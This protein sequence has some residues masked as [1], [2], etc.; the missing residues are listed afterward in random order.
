M[1]HETL[2]HAPPLHTSCA[3]SA[4][5]PDPSKQDTL[6]GRLQL[7][8]G[9]VSAPAALYYRYLSTL[10][11]A[12]AAMAA[13]ITVQL[14]AHGGA[15]TNRRNQGPTQAEAGRSLTDR[16]DQDWLHAWM[17]EATC[18]GFRSEQCASTGSE[19]C[20]LRDT[21]FSQPGEI[22]EEVSIVVGCRL[23]RLPLQS[24]PWTLDIILSPG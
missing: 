14:M 18:P 8:I 10:P 5:Q 16:R 2:C 21:L 11:S 23:F 9:V 12:S 7:G 20:H 19:A 1:G 17:K 22:F 24:V 6:L 13:A 3:D 15:P 4:H